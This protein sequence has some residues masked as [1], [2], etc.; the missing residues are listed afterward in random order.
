VLE[1]LDKPVSFVLVMFGSPMVVKIV[2]DFN[3]TVELVNEA[4]QQTGSSHCF[5]GIHKSTCEY[6]LQE[7]Q[8]GIGDWDTEEYEKMLG[9]AFHNLFLEAIEDDII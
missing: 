5:D 9:L 4:S 7:V 1:F 6:V 3:A 2:E 8:P